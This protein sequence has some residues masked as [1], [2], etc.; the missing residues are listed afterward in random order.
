MSSIHGVIFGKL[1][2]RYI[3][4]KESADGHI[5]VVGGAGSGK[6]S[7]VAIP[8]LLAWREA[9]FCIDIKGELYHH[10]KQHRTNAKVFN[11]TNTSANTYGYDPFYL[12]KKSDNPA[13]E[14]RAIAHALVPLP[15]DTKE[16]FWV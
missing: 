14:A 11:P 6:T 5:L 10:T 7:C 9:V 8:S 15:P 16:P 2:N 4:K 1:G 13:Q 3:T 12:L